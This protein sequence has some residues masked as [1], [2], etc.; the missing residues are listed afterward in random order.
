MGRYGTLDYPAL[1][2]SSFALGVG[3]LVVGVLGSAVGPL[4][5]HGSTS[6]GDR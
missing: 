4:V 6:H 2:R 1:A 3:L 5:R